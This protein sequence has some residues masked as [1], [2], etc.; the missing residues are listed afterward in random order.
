MIKN[1][2]KKRNRK[3]KE[4]RREGRQEKEEEEQEKEKEEE[5][6]SYET[7]RRTAGRGNR[8]GQVP[9]ANTGRPQMATCSLRQLVTCQKGN[10]TS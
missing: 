8:K 4:E 10:G 7:T 1:D 3:K 2:N 5:N 6:H 9:E